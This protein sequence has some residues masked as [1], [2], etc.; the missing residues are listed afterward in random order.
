VRVLVLALLCAPTFADEPGAPCTIDEN[1]R[2][3]GTDTTSC[4]EKLEAEAKTARADLEKLETAA[5]VARA[6]LRVNTAMK[7]RRVKK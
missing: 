2:V 5:R 4:V 6:E 3:T 7:K 1:L